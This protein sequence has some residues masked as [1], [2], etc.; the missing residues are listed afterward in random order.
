MAK[1]LWIITLIIASISDFIYMINYHVSKDKIDL[2]GIII[3]TIIVIL[4]ALA[5]ILA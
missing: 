2:I 3:C 4:E 1:V 5:L